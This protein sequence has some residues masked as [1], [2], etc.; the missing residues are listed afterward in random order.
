M[1]ALEQGPG[2]APSC[3]ERL[4]NPNAEYE[5]KNPH[6]YYQVVHLL[7]RLWYYLEICFRVR[8]IPVGFKILLILVLLLTCLWY[9]LEICIRVQG[10]PVGL[11]ILQIETL[12]S[13]I[14]S[15]IS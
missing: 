4:K 5:T 7:T 6:G 2:V 3:W 10:I 9:Y 15:Y 8:G 14:S 12:I 13:I 1:D 11:K